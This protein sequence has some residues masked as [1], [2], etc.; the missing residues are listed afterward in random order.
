MGQA[1][2]QAGSAA[3]QSRNQTGP[4]A[5]AHIECRCGQ[6]LYLRGSNAQARKKLAK[7][8]RIYEP[9]FQGCPGVA[10]RIQYQLQ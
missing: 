6:S 2:R 4:K 3:R 10:H 7:K 5:V 9:A 8:T 1:K